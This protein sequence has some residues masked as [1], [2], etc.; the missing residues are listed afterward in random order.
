MRTETTELPR[1][2]A[3]LLGPRYWPGWGLLALLAV[4]V[5]VLPLRWLQ[6][7]GRR[8]GRRVGRASARARRVARVNLE[9]CFPE[10]ADE[11]REALVRRNF[12]SLG[13]AVCETA[14]AW[15]WPDWRVR[16]LFDCEGAAVPQ[17]CRDRGQGA[18]ILT[19]HFLTLE[20]G[21]RMACLVQ[22]GVAVYRPNPDPWLDWVM[23]RGRMRSARAAIPRGDVKAILRALRAGELLWYAPD[24][25]PGRFR[26]E[27][28]PF[29]AVREAQTTPA[30][31]LLARR[32][33]A[34]V[35]PFTPLRGEDGRFALRFGEPLP[36]FP[37]TD[38]TDDTR[39]V[40]QV[41]ADA[42]RQAPDQYLWTYRRFQGART[43]SGASVYD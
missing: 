12:E 8:L 39:R 27:T 23:Y 30:T 28:V 18:L 41:L 34:A 21:A 36:D 20:L 38:V 29:F 10:L 25:F 35:V 5:T 15:F 43:A 6:A 33:G 40:N 26:S 31:A 3:T 37:S 42:I 19:G 9:L 2:R 16:R 7:V 17:A 11:Q 32:T 4:L 13:A 14:A 24:H 22:P 1:F